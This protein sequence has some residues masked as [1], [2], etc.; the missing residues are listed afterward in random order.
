MAVGNPGCK[1]S[2]RD[3]QVNRPLELRLPIRPLGRIFLHNCFSNLRAQVAGINRVSCLPAH[4]RIMRGT[5]S[6]SADR[7]ESNHR[8]QRPGRAPWNRRWNAGGENKDAAS[9]SPCRPNSAV[10]STTTF[11]VIAISEGLSVEEQGGAI[12]AGMGFR[13]SRVSPDC[14]H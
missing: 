2:V 11:A 12:A 4:R 13:S 10:Y 1:N 14:E 9:S 5:R 6:S 8:C 7:V 3:R